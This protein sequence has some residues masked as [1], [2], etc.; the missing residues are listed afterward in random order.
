MPTAGAAN[1]SAV[2]PA[3]GSSLLTRGPPGGT[4]P[5]P[6]SPASPLQPSPA[7]HGPG[8]GSARTAREGGRG[9]GV[10]PSPL[11]SPP[12]CRGCLEVPPEFS[13]SPSLPVAC[14]EPFLQTHTWS[15]P[16]CGFQPHFDRRAGTCAAPGPTPPARALTLGQ[17]RRPP[18]PRP[19]PGT[20]PSR[21]CCRAGGQAACDSTTALPP[22]SPFSRESRG[23]GTTPPT[24][25]WQPMGCS[26][27]AGHSS[28]G[29]GKG[30]KVGGGGCV[31]AGTS[32][33][34]R[35]LLV[36]SGTPPPRANTP[37]PQSPGPWQ[38]DRRAWRER[39]RPC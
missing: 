24:A 2:V 14:W 10:Q 35:C 25:E 3:R 27:P 5:S 15:Q 37:S 22:S 39:G 18:G 6:S 30:Q 21:A 11:P 33:L 26:G 36:T 31:T 9:S 29:L 16:C 23:R 19:R 1:V 28:G 34:G 32:L 7:P 4:P 8:G 17:G 38:A 13:S 20:E 12:P